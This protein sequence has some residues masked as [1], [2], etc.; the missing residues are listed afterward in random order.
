MGV[1]ATPASA[2]SQGQSRV[3]FAS[4]LVQGEDVGPWEVPEDAQN[5]PTDRKAHESA[6]DARNGSSDGSFEMS[7]DTDKEAPPSA[8]VSSLKI[9]QR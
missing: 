1:E 8:P 6:P 5:E 4:D 3:T 9:T 2:R 7:P